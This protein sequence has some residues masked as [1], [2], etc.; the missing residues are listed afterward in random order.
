VLLPFRLLQAI[1]H[2]LNFFSAKYSGKTLVSHGGAQ[3]READLKQ[4]MIWGNLVEAG[5]GASQGDEAPDLVP[6]SWELVRRSVEGQIEVLAKS[7]L[8]YDLTADGT[9]LYSNGSSVTSLSPGGK[10]TRLHRDR[11]IQQVVALG[12]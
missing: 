11:L 10:V 6:A 3:Q 7:V 2:Y 4:M 9:L 12:Y 8:A 5:E 1:I